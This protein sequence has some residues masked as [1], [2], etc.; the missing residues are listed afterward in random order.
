MIAG[1][2]C[3]PRRAYTAKSSGQIAREAWSMIFAALSTHSKNTNTCSCVASVHVKAV[4]SF[5]PC[6][7]DQP[8]TRLPKADRLSTKNSKNLPRSALAHVKKQIAGPHAS[9]RWMSLPE[10][11]R[12]RM[13]S[14][15]PVQHSSVISSS[16]SSNEYSFQV[17]IHQINFH[18]MCKL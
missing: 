5:A 2:S 4:I 11:Q 15:T 16:N 3:H 17:Q 1:T 6:S 18:R 7:F 13:S 8:P 14:G 12:R 9:M 10:F